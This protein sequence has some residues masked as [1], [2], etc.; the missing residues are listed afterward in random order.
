MTR[1]QQIIGGALVLALAG[2]G[3]YMYIT[4]HHTTPERSVEW[5][6]RFTLQAATTKFPAISSSGPATKGDLPSEVKNILP[7]KFRS[8]TVAKTGYGDGH[9]GF[10]VRVAVPDQ[11]N[12]SALY[13]SH[14]NTMR[15]SGWSLL[16]GERY[17]ELFA[18]QE[19]EHQQ[20]SMR[21]TYE[22]AGTDI[23]VSLQ[24][25]SQ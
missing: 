20:Y 25:Y 12:L 18:F 15:T 21:V 22:I 16:T 9:T 19:A 24:V 1:S 11:L 6:R 23:V 8:L 13:R 17:R 14:R 3:S 2:A 4:L 5:V 10:T 7:A